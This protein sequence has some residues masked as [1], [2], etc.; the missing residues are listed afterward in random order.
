MILNQTDSTL[1]GPL[2][3]LKG[4]GNSLKKLEGAYKRGMKNKKLLYDAALR[5]TTDTLTL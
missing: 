1:H 4:N 2:F 5:Y 3:V